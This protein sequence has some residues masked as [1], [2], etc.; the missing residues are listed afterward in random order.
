MENLEK[1]REFLRRKKEKGV[2][3]ELKYGIRKLSIGVVS[4]V[5]GLCTC[6]TPTMVSAESMQDNKEAIAVALETGEK[7]AS[8]NSNSE[9][10]GYAP[11]AKYSFQDLKFNP[12]KIEKGMHSNQL[13]FEIYGKHNIAASTDNW[14]IRLQID[15]RLA[16]Y[17]KSIEVDSKAPSTRRTLVRQSDTIGRKTNIWEVNYIRA[18]GGLFAGGETTDTQVAP[19]GVITFEKNID[20]IMADIGDE[21]LLS[22]KL[23]YRIYLTSVK[24]GG[25]IVPGID[26]TGTFRTYMDEQS[27]AEESPNNTEWFKYAAIGARY[28]QD[29]KMLGSN[30]AIIVD[31]NISKN[32]N[33]SYT[34][35]AKETPWSLKFKVDKRLVKYVEGIELHKMGAIAAVTPDFSLENK[36]NA[37]VADLSIERDS[38]KENYGMGEIT[39]NDL[40]KI[41]DFNNASPRPVVIRYVYRLNKPMDEILEEL[42]KEA[43][44]ET[45]NSFGQDFDF[46]AWISDVNG[47]LIR[48]TW[49]TGYYRIQD[50]DGDGKTD[51]TESNKETSPYISEPVVKSAYEGDKKISASVLLNEN[52]GKGNVAIL[53]N[54]NG[55][56]IARVENLDAVDENGLPK[57]VVK[58]F[59]FS[60]DDAQKLGKAGDELVV[61]IIPSD[62]RYQEPEI[63]KTILKEAPIA[64]DEPVK[65][66]KGAK[67]DKDTEFAKS[68][69]ANVDKMPEGTTYSW[70]T[71]P[72]TSKTGNTTGVVLVKVP[73]RDEAFEVTIPVSVAQGLEVTVETPEKQIEGVA[74]KENTKVIVTNQEKSEVTES[75]DDGKNTGLSIEKN[76]DLT[77]VPG[78]L[79][80]GETG[81]ATYEEQE[82]TLHATIRSEDGKEEKSADVI[83]TVQRDADKDGIP[84]VKD[85]D[86][87]NDGVKDQEELDKG[88]DPKDPNSVPQ[89]D[90]DHIGKVEI[91]N[92]NQTI[93]EGDAIE[94]I[95]IKTE[96]QKATVKVGDLP[97]GLNYNEQ[98]N[99]ISGIPEISDWA[100]AETSRKLQTTITVTNEKGATVKKEVEI[101]VKRKT[102]TEKYTAQGGVVNKPYGQTATADEI[103][104]AVTTDAPKEKVQSVEVTGTIPTEGQNKS[105]SVVVTYVDGSSDAVEVVVN[106]GNASDVYEAIGQTITVDKGGQPKA[107][108]GIANKAELPANT[109]YAW[110]QPVDTTVAGETAGTVIATYPDGSEDYVTVPVIVND[111]ETDTEK[112]TAQGGVVNKPYGQT[113]TADEIVAVVTT[114]AP[115]EEIQSIV[116]TGTIPTEGQNK[117]VSVVVTYGD[118][119]SDAV[120]VVVNYGNASDVYEATGQAITVD[121]G[122]QPKAEDGIANKAE[123]PA[124]TTY[125]WQQPV[126]TTVAGETAGTVIA[127]YP[128]GSEDYVTVPVIVNDTETDAEKYTAQGG[129]VNKPYGQ[130]VT[131]DEV[132]AAVSTDA[133]EGK[134]QSIGV[135][136]TIPTEGK[137]NEVS[138]SVLYADDTTDVVTVVVNYG[139][140]SGTYEP[141]GQEITVNKGKQPKAEDGIANKNELPEGTE[142][143][144]KDAID[145]SKPGEQMGT[146]VVTY[147]DGSK[148]EVQ[149]N[150]KVL[151]DQTDADKYNPQTE[152][153]VIK[154][155]EKPD[156][157]DNVI[158]KDEL[159]KGTVIE[160]VTP[161]GAI[162]LEKPGKYT[163]TL[164]ITYPDGSKEKVDVPVLVQ[165]EADK[166]ISGNK[167]NHNHATIN[168]PSGKGNTGGKQNGTTAQKP[169]KT[170]DTTKIGTYAAGLLVSILA[171]LKLAFAKKR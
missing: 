117:S 119:S 35:S 19:N 25:K 24:D 46:D 29:E 146:V 137:N 15:E 111:T 32:A 90:I 78:N 163:G 59:T 95:E 171:A 76:G 147:P 52:A 11:N 12:K 64:V 103:V 83:V 9:N 91:T 54:K 68:G 4:C 100:E 162:D 105:V 36:K 159:P 139:D 169:P 138:V 124:N 98:N 160:D 40:N 157:T 140:A 14:K 104:A 67:L 150:I 110:Q 149:V 51:D 127:T 118:G 130:T 77:G 152:Q 89:A 155:G 167:D 86:D 153:E 66:Y 143:T 3:R 134:V 75:N 101:V 148:D 41:V 165:K 13:E 65:T 62:Q 56:E 48:N 44:V 61:K 88:S 53:V 42:K 43:G 85:E 93:A 21:K 108:D 151:D 142:Y 81:S 161:E 145:V 39:N 37:K 144:W 154:P 2:R 106:Y 136:G 133:P 47:N 168:K 1:M 141:A 5:I 38:S 50:V 120:E 17:I 27:E 6:I 45:G 92:A 8:G 128:D 58:E 107:E 135:T 97:T 96:D 109:T 34:I 114:D 122:G 102:D 49:G 10:I 126:D 113:A 20:E 131:V 30:G 99:T 71:A 94:V 26:S 16:K 112:Y 55:E 158:N 116:V 28:M 60:V 18:N 73:D 63:G 7:E 72:D 74:V 129:V 156:L 69:I 79:V 164:E 166:N 22:D 33:F 87:D 84:D 132:I 80:W 31:H 82:V 121:K 23:G 70:K 123:L 170:G 115:K 57:T 125:A